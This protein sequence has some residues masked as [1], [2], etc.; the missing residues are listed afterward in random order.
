MIKIQGN[1]VNTMFMCKAHPDHIEDVLMEHL[2]D[3]EKV[4]PKVS[5]SKYK[6]SF[7]LKTTDQ[8]GIVQNS[9]ICIKLHKVDEEYTSIE[10][11]NLGGNQCRFYDH[12]HN[13]KKNV[14]NF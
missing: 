10:F 2:R 8:G 14:L 6:I 4:D 1:A 12:F 3:V 5:S 11:Q 13:Y 7:S 9:S